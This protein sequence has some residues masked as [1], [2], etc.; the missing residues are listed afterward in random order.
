MAIGKNEL[1]TVMG[2]FGTGVTIITTFNREGTLHGLT[3][4]AFSSLSLVPPLCLICVDKKAESYASFD[5][6]KVFTVNILR[7]DQEELSR[8]FRS[9]RR[10]KVYRSRVQARRQRRAG[11]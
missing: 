3:A 11:P 9:E 5:D 10:R 2:H 6:S 4:N 8:A 7:D 1:R